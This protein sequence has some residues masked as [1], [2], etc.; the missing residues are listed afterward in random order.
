[1]Q[2]NLQPAFILHRRPYRDSSLLLEVLTAEHGRL[3]LIARGARR[4]TR[5]GSPGLVLQPF[6]PL[7]LSFRG[8]NELRTLGASE[9][10]GT[11]VPLQGERLFSGLYLNELLM[12]LLH[13]FDPHPRLFAL[14]AS[15]LERLGRT[16]PG[17][18][19]PAESLLRRFELGLLDELGYCIDL[20]RDA[21]SGEPV[22]ADGWY[23]YHPDQGMVEQSL[24]VQEGHPAYAGKDLLRIAAGE[25]G[26]EMRAPSKRLLRQILATHLGGEPLRSRELFRAAHGSERR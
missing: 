9:L 18:T 17:R 25:F 12:R 6:A 3:G 10:A 21:V 1:M 14:Y 13:R 23:S 11:P 5:K 20:A 16:D 24:S 2:V 19:D 7:L 22:L 8:R 4:Q 15:T 26:G